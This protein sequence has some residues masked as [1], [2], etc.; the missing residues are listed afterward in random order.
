MKNINLSKIDVISYI[1]LHHDRY[2]HLIRAVGKSNVIVEDEGTFENGIFRYCEINIDGQYVDG[3]AKVF[4]TTSQWNAYLQQKNVQRIDIVI[5]EVMDVNP[6]QAEYKTTMVE[7][8]V[9]DELINSFAMVRSS[10][11]AVCMEYLAAQNSMFVNSILDKMLVE[12][13]SRK[14]NDMIAVF[15]RCNDWDKVFHYMLFDTIMISN[16]NRGNFLTLAATIHNEAVTSRLDTQFQIEALLLGAAG[17]LSSINAGCDYQKRLLAEYV[18]L[19]KRYSIRRMRL[20]QWALPLKHEVYNHIAYLA[21]L[22]FS[23]VSFMRSLYDEYEI[24]NIYKVMT[25]EVSSYWKRHHDFSDFEYGTDR[26]K[27]LSKSKID[28]FIINMI[29][30]LNVAVNKQKGESADDKSER[31]ID[32]L[33]K[34]TEDN[35]YTKK[36]SGYGLKLP[37]AYETQAIIQL[38]K[39]YCLQQKCATCML[40]SKMTK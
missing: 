11:Y 15:N 17:F 39:E 18:E 26:N 10:N 13:M 5:Y 37:T 21:A 29:I 40:F 9:P 12:R 16:V 28:V 3:D 34:V 2:T 8:T 33:T 24:K 30:P 22:I 38:Y 14:S 20:D 4:A 6:R 1:W 36:W 35:K 7:I 25:K 27:S 23:R 19:E 31:A 32:L